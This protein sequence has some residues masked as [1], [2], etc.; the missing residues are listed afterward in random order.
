MY[1]KASKAL[2]KAMDIAQKIKI[3]E[4]ETAAYLIMA[5]MYAMKGNLDSA[6]AYTRR[7]IVLK[8]S[9]YEQRLKQQ[10]VEVQVKYETEKMERDNQL[11]SQ[12]VQLKAVIEGQEKERRHIARELHDSVGQRLAA[13]KL[14]WQKMP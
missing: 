11:L 12:E 8:D 5:K 7:Y 3:L 4:E 6:F 14:S 13:I 9:V 1:G 2:Y 10:I